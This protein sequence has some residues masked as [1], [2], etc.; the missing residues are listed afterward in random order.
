MKYE[1]CIYIDGYDIC[2]RM[3]IR[4]HK[5]YEK[6]IPLPQPEG[7]WKEILINFITGLSLSLHRGIVYDTILVIVDKYSKM[8]QFV[9]YN[10]ETTAE[11][12]T[13]II[14][15]EIIKHFDI[16]KFY[17]LDRGSLFTLV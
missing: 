14:K 16:F 11:K 7:I 8:I 6:L 2:Q 10:K 4:Y 17:I 9:P 5:L 3:I 15:S 12:L 13:K 1:I